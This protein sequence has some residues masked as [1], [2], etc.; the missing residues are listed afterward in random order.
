[1]RNNIILFINY[2]AKPGGSFAVAGNIFA[3]C[4]VPVIRIAFKVS[5]KSLVTDK[6]CHGSIEPQIINLGINNNSNKYYH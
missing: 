4:A 1:V 6:E 5:D 3:Q 2:I